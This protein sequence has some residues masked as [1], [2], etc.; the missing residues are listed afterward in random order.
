MSLVD[1]I[2]AD[3]QPDFV[4]VG[5]DQARQRE[6]YGAQGVQGDGCSSGSP[7][8]EAQTGSTTNG[9]VPARPRSRQLPATVSMISDDAS[10]PVLA[11]CTPMSVAT[12]WICPAMMSVGIS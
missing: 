6:Q 9:V 10:M 12:A 3:Q 1:D 11:A 7:C 4:E 8:M 5:R 2:D